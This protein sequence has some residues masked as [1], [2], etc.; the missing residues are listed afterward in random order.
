MASG[1]A[2]RIGVDID[3]VVADLLSAWL[4]RYNAENGTA[5]TPADLTR[6]EIWEDLSCIKGDIFKHLTPSVYDKVLPFDGVA[7][8]LKEIEGLGHSVKFVTNCASNDMTKNLEM[9]RAKI[10]WLSKHGLWRFVAG[11]G[12]GLAW[13]SKNDVDIDWLIDDHIGN[14][15]KFTRGYPVLLTRPHNRNLVWNGKRIKHLRDVLPM[16]KYG[17]NDLGLISPEGFRAA[18]PVPAVRQFE[19]GATRDTDTGKLD[20]E[21]FFSPA[22]LKRR[23]EFMHKNRFQKDGSIRAGDNWAKGIPTDVYMKSLTRHFMDIWLAHREGKPLP[24]EEVCALMFNAEGLLY[25]DLKKTAS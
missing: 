21:A 8:A 11:C 10:D 14:L 13:E 5:W 16:L 25:E 2:L 12:K 3:D 18:C 1:K 6:W 22:V 7:E 9:L 23:A 17:S 4:N 20:Y 19:T 24:Q 15:E